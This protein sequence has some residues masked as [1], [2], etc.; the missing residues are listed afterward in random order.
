MKKLIIIMLGI[1]LL[2]GFVFAGSLLNKTDSQLT[3]DKAKVDA[4]KTT[5]ITSINVKASPMTCDDRECWSDI[6]QPNLIQTQFR[7]TK[8][9]CTQR[10]K[11]IECII[12]DQVCKET[13][14][15]ENIVC[16]E[17]GEKEECIKE[18]TEIVQE[19]IKYGNG[20]C[21]QNSTATNECLA[22]ADYT[23]TQLISMR[24]AFVKQRLESYA[25]SIIVEQS[26]SGNTQ[27]DDGGVI[28]S[29]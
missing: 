24:D 16:I 15:V 25:D 1:F 10:N 12:Y 20:N 17:Y 18:G 14:D 27:I 2:I 9:Y 26:K 21:I 7:T 13:K 29:K 6:N 11:T 28:T 19:C 3:I 22:Y 5:G 23:A 4:I 8:K